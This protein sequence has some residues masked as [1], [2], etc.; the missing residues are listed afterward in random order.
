MFYSFK[1]SKDKKKSTAAIVAAENQ[2]LTI[3][4][5]LPFVFI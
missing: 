1:L 2:N 3:I 5:N 4:V